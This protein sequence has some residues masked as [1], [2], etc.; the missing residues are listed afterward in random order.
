MVTEAF[1]SLDRLEKQLGRDS[2]RHAPSANRPLQ[3]GRERWWSVGI[4]WGPF[5]QSDLRD[6]AP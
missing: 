5:I 6:P 1:A 2:R 4:S 3:T